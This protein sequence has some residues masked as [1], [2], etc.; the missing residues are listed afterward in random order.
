MQITQGGATTG[1]YIGQGSKGK[2]GLLTSV[3][4]AR[5]NKHL[6]LFVVLFCSRLYDNCKFKKR[7]MR[8]CL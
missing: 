2:S 7:I 1:V 3:C 4:I 6:S 8:G 5:L